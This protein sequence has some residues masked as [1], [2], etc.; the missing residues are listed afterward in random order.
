[1]RIC[2]FV[3]L[4]VS[5]VKVLVVLWL[6]LNTTPLPIEE[7]VRGNRR[8]RRNA[9][10]MSANAVAQEASKGMSR[11]SFEVFGKVQNVFM[12]KYTKKAAD[13]Y[14]VRGYIVNTEAK[15]V[16]GEACGPHD[17]IKKFKIWLRTKGSP[18]SRIDRAVFANEKD[19][20][21]CDD[22]KAKFEVRKVKLANG[23]YWA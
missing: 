7:H 21:S 5:F 10:Q 23:T 22:L 4:A 6:L 15:T 13:R 11:V 20:G 16:K 2:L 3:C 1:M 12:R 19:V 8:S 17:S 18:K 9:V 14:G